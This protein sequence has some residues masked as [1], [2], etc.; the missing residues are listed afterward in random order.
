MLRKES[1]LVCL[2]SA[3]IVSIPL[4]VVAS[5]YYC[6]P[7]HGNTQS[8]S[9]SESM[10]WG[11]LE[12]VVL[13]HHF[14]DGT[15]NDGDIV[16]LLSGYH[17]DFN[18]LALNA[19]SRTNAD[20]ITIQGAP[21]HIPRLSQIVATGLTK[22]KFI[23][24][25]LSPDY[26]SPSRVAPHQ[27]DIKVYIV[28]TDWTGA[29]LVFE[30][31]YF[32]TVEDASGWDVDDWT[33]LSWCG[34]QGGNTHTV[35]RG[36]T[37]RN[38]RTAFAMNGNSL[39]EKNTV[40]GFSDDGIRFSGPN[41]VLQDNVVINTYA[42]NAAYYGASSNWHADLIQMGHEDG[43]NITI[44]R[45]YLN[46]DYNPDRTPRAGTQGIFMQPQLLSGRIENNVVACTAGTH[47]ISQDTGTQG[48]LLIANNTVVRPYNYGDLPNIY[49]KYPR[50]VTVR[51]NIANGFPVPDAANSVLSDHNLNVANYNLSVEFVDYAHGDF[52][53]ASGS[54]FIDTGTNDGAPVEDLTKQS[55][56]LGRATDIGAYECGGGDQSP[57]LAVIGD[58]SVTAGTNLAFDVSGT[59]PNGR[60][61]VY[62]AT[63]L[64]TGATFVERRFA[65]TPASNQV[66]SYQ[67]T[68]TVS[69]D[70]TQASETVTITV[71]AA[72]VPNSAPVLG[73]I[74]N[75]SIPENQTLT[76]SVSATDAD[77]GPSP[78]TYSAT[79][80]PM[81]A[82]FSGQDFSWT[83]G[84]DQAGTYQVTFVASDGLEHA[85]EI[86]TVTVAN[87]NR[88]PALSGIGD[89]SVDEN[90]TLTFS[91]SGSD[92][93]GGSLTY[94]A[95]QTP[96]GA[97][98]SGQDFSWT[99]TSGQAGTYQITFVVSDGELQD[100]RTM[101]VTVIGAAPDGT[102]PVVAQSLP[103]PDAIQVPTNNLT[104][105]HVTDAGAGV[106]PGSVVIRVND[107]IVYQGD[108]QMY[109]GESGRCGR[110]GQKNDYRFIYQPAQSYD[111]D[112]T[113]TVRVNAADLQ[114]NAMPEYSYCFVTE[115]RTFGANM[116]VGKSTGA[117]QEKSPVTATDSIGNVWIVWQ[118][119]PQG[120]R[121]I[122]AAR[123]APG[124]AAFRSPVVLTRDPQD[125]CNPDVAVGS[126]GKVY[127]VWQDNRR[128]NWDIYGSVCSSGQTF[129]R[130]S[131][132]SDSNDNEINPVIAVDAQSPNQ[133]HVAWQDD[134][135]G[136]QDIYVAVSANAF[137]GNTVSQVT[138]NAAD[139]IQPDIT[140]DGQNVIYIVWTD[141]RNGQA[142]IYGAASNV[143][144]WTNVPVVASASDQTGP[145]I[146]AEPGGSVLHLLWVDDATGDQ[147]VY[148]ASAQGLPSSPLVGRSIV[149]DTSGADQLAP[150]IVCATGGKVFACW[151]D[152]RHEG[153]YSSDT[154]LYV[155][156]LVSGAAKTNVLVG[157]EQTN[158]SQHEPA[159]GVDAHGQPYV[160]WTDDRRGSTQVYYSA[161]TFIDPVALDSKLVV[162]SAGATIGTE[163]SAID[164]PEDVSIVIPPQACQADLRMTISRILNPQSV[165]VECLGS[166]DFGP[167]GI[168]FDLPVTVTV[169]YRYANRGNSGRAKPYWYDS[170]TGVLSQQ[171]ITDVETI[172]ISAGL[173]ALRFKTTHFTPFYLV[174]GDDGTTQSGVEAYGGCSLSKAGR[175]SP[176][177]LIIPCAVVAL[178]MVILRRRDKRRQEI[179]E[180]SRE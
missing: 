163:P 154:D 23:G 82:T 41:T 77:G 24:L 173:S 26:A 178:T 10:P 104:T 38:M 45:N 142:D 128:G 35:L 160:I 150:A 69:N 29:Y 25:R 71:E 70:Q 169:P 50:H 97:N 28:K 13:A 129:S 8:G 162:A 9:G 81:G 132:V 88:P 48:G 115:M 27:H 171:G 62:S 89:R 155:A 57:V 11:T 148:Y 161:T 101:N 65:W 138:A 83:P 67:V 16:L 74:G 95:G 116:Q 111:F 166:Y 51:N 135:N 141:M 60:A 102:A 43:N 68:F 19:A 118:N 33:L 76:F 151:Q 176:T 157:D 80:L 5:V 170:L 109:A 125:Q 66:G 37:F 179:T 31:C 180:G 114:G 2:V 34:I 107:Q 63:G 105:L 46:C 112:Q 143:G 53:L 85:S 72:A 12:S 49:L 42:N 90:N 54:H 98:F 168:Y 75:K 59:D 122:Y 84:Y 92:P 158:A 91:I 139:Q 127:V 56:P 18:S 164:Q 39:A 47:G 17:G 110:S 93:D 172:E 136:N 124:E 145:V 146:A 113:V 61:L 131:R 147:D 73:V 96:A 175:G 165:R 86:V 6:D 3:I 4:P 174:A 134:R 64:P 159:L 44:R 140:A 55:R 167:S 108:V 121:D 32:C 106:N 152:S 52:R 120:N 7:A 117:L 30:N 14:D 99:P 22:W 149:D 20:Y 79:G 133:L 1:L 119:G 15:I 177:E 40:D 144:P 153:N 100:S 94:S 103:E 130:E 78:L 58:K 87:V 36:N 21:G 126:D 123:M 156:E 137:V